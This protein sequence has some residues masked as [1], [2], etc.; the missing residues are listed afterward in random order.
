VLRDHPDEKQIVD[1]GQREK[2]RI[3]EGDDEKA[4]TT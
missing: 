4:G 2:R 1:L 3:Q